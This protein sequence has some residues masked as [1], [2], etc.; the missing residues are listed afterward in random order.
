MHSRR[1]WQGV[2][3][4]EW[5]WRTQQAAALAW[6]GATQT[7]IA[8]YFG[9]HKTSLTHWMH[10]WPPFR[11]A[12]R[13]GK[14]H[15]DD[16]VEGTLYDMAT[17]GENNTAT[18]FWLKNRRPNEWRDKREI[19]V[20]GDVINKQEDPLRHLAMA[21]INIVTAGVASDDDTMI[22]ITPQQEPEHANSTSARSHEHQA[23]TSEP[24]SDDFTLDL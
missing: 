3:E 21:V 6:H 11:E 4:A 18:I 10:A 22:D 8:A 5:R 7:E 24:D 15:A 20:G 1:G 2:D 14:D 23:P 16:R 13:M 19:E 17:S 9:I 12:L